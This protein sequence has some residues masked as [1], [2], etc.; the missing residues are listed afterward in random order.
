MGLYSLFLMLLW[1]HGPGSGPSVNGGPTLLE[2]G[3]ALLEKGQ[4]DQTVPVLK[5]AMLEDPKS[6]DAHNYYGF[7]LGRTGH[8]KDALLEFDQALRLNPHD[9]DALDRKSTR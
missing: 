9:P 3:I 5:R 6:T 1:M 2:E 7:A 4:V 8:L